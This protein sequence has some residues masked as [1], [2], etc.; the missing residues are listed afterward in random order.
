MQV[1]EVVTANIH[2]LL[3]H[4]AEL[5]GRVPQN[6]L[7]GLGIESWVEIPICSRPQSLVILFRVLEK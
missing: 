6:E 4:L 3:D 2:L 5:L 1:T 7:G